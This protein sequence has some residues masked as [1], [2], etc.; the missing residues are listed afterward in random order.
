MDI[1]TDT[2]CPVACMIITQIFCVSDTSHPRISYF[3]QSVVHI[4]GISR[5]SG[6]GLLPGTVTV[7]VILVG[8]IHKKRVFSKLCP[9]TAQVLV[10]IVGVFRIQTASQCETSDRSVLIVPISCGTV[11][12]ACYIHRSH[13]C[14]FRH[15]KSAADS[16]T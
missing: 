6:Q 4:I 10:H 11:Y 15:K 7:S 13:S 1:S 14:H 12:S 8:I 2:F 5:Q 16:C 9:H 3:H